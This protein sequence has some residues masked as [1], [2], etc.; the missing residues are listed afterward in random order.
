M[1]DGKQ[2]TKE[3]DT[4]PGP[5]VKD[6]L[7]LVMVWQL[8]HPDETD[9]KGAIEA[10][11]TGELTPLLASQFL[12]LTIR[13]L[14]SKREL[15]NVTP[16]GHQRMPGTARRRALDESEDE[17]QSWKESTNSSALQLLQWC[18]VSLSPRQ[19][20]DRWGLLIPPILRMVDDVEAKFKVIGLNALHM[21]L[22][23]I[24]PDHI[25][26]TGMGPVIEAAIRPAMYSLPSLTPEP[27]SVAILEAGF[28]AWMI[29]ALRR[30]PPQTGSFDIDQYAVIPPSP[31]DYREQDASVQGKSPEIGTSY[32]L[33][34]HLKVHMLHGYIASSLRHIEAKYSQLARLLLVHLQALLR[35]A[36]P[37]M[38]EE[39]HTIMPLVTEYLQDPLVA[40]TN[41]ELLVQAARTL[42]TI[43]ACAWTMIWFWRSELLE[44][45]CDAW[46]NVCNA[47]AEEDI[48][49]LKRSALLAARADLMDCAQTMLQALQHS[50]SFTPE[51]SFD[52][53]MGEILE[54]VDAEPLCGVLFGGLIAGQDQAA[55]DRRIGSGR[56]VAE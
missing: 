2:L 45:I 36:G 53:L 23:K 32:E 1:V 47:L 56:P 17:I 48:P 7:D 24:S 43:L 16:Q 49:E 22:R 40:K 26:R 20:E 18:L 5:W 55:S 15:P 33:L 37:K 42:K 35:V 8:R 29:L 30:W 10:V 14:F 39:K 28:N 46:I 52:Q 21:L 50:E 34:V 27:D 54:V 51:M 38:I 41:P 12:E 31:I 9:P 13:P 3:L 44:A 6:A 25:R 11:K 19:L 4:K